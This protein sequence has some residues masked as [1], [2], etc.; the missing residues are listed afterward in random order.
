V[1][2][3]FGW[4]SH[5]HWTTS[6]S[7]YFQSL[8]RKAG[9]WYHQAVCVCVCL[10]VRLYGCFPFQTFNQRTNFSNLG[11]DVMPMETSQPHGAARQQATAKTPAKRSAY[12]IL[13][14]I[15]V[16]VILVFKVSFVS[17][18]PKSHT[19]LWTYYLQRSANEHPST[20]YF[21]RCL[22]NFPNVLGQIANKMGLQ[23]KNLAT[24]QFLE[25][26]IISSDASLG[27]W[28]DTLR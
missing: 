11:S 10:Y 21:I 12:Q 4:A 23:K 5:N 18:I 8:R 6:F 7:A 26:V 20:C 19:R 3:L 15:V 27:S 16:F 25:S 9:L 28:N 14:V 17:F 13:S 24:S 1:T 22:C 2:R